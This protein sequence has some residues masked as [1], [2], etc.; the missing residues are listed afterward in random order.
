MAL[1][2]VRS[3]RSKLEASGRNSS[4][5]SSML[6]QDASVKSMGCLMVGMAQQAV[7][8]RNLRREP[9][10]WKLAGSLRTVLN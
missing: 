2:S 6:R 7:R 3:L 1:R 8:A 10:S 9:Q 4:K 5:W